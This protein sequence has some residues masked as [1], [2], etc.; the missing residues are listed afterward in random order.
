MR[1]LREFIAAGVRNPVL[2]NLI[3]VCALA[4][5]YF[6][7]R[8]MVQEAYPEFSVDHVEIVI[9]WPGAA[10]VDVERAITIPVEEAVEGIGGVRQ[11]SSHSSDDF[12]S[13]WLTLNTRGVDVDEVIKEVRNE[14]DQISHRLPPDAEK[15]IIRELIVR[16]EVI[17]I[18]IS[19]DVSERALKR[20]AK[21][22]KTDLLAMPEVSQVAISG[23]RDDEIIVELSEESLQA[24]NLTFDQ[25]MAAIARSSLELS[26]GT[27]RTSEEE[28]SLRIAGR[29]LRASEYEKLVVIERPNAVVHLSDI[30]EIREGFE[31]QTIRGRFNGKPALSVIVYK[32]PQE[33]TT[34]I[35]RAVRT[36]VESQQGFLPQRVTMS[37]WADSS[38]HVEDRVQ[39]L[40][41]N[42]LLG[43]ILVFAALT[44]FLEM[45]TAFW[46]A[47]GIPV[48]FGGALIVMAFSGETL[49]MI[50]MFALIMVSGII[51]DDAI[52]IAE[53]IHNRRRA[54][55]APQLASINGAN[56]V[57]VPVLGSS[58]TTIMTFIPLLFI[59]GAMGNVIRVLPVVVIGAILASA[60]EAFG[61]LPAHLAG[62]KVNESNSYKRRVN[63]LRKR[64]EKAIDH[65]VEYW[66]RPVYRLSL[67]YR[68]VTI[69]GALGMLAFVVGLV[70][71]DR[72]S[73][74]FYPKETGAILRARVRYPEG[75]PASLSED[76]A[77]RM[78]LAALA[79]N[80]DPELA[81]EV[82]GPLVKN[83]YAV[84]GEFAD[85]WPERG[86]NLCE[87][88]IELMPA[89]KRG[90]DEQ[91]IIEKWREKIG[92]VHDAIAY[93][94]ER[95]EIG[96]VKAPI[97]VRFMGSNLEDLNDARARL[98][99]KLSTYAGVT[100]VYSDLLPGKRELRVKLKP[101]ARTL[102][103]TLED[104]ARQLRQ[105]FY[106][107]E[108]VRL[109]RGREEVIVRV[110]YREEERRSITELNQKHFKLPTGQ[111]IPFEEAVEVAW[112]QGFAMIG[113]QDGKRRVRVFADV[114]ERVANATRVFEELE[115][116]YLPTLVN[117]YNDMYWAFGGHRDE[118]DMS[119]SSLWTGF[120]M[121]MLAVYA[122]LAGMLRSYIKPVIILIAVPFGIIGAVFG[123]AIMGFDVT[124]MSLFGVVA[125]SGV[126]VNDSLVLLD[127]V[128]TSIR[129]GKS[130][131]EAVAG[132][133]ERRFRAVVLTSITTVAGLAPLML[134]RSTQAAPLVPMAISLVFGIVFATV[135]TLF[136]VPSLYLLVND[137]RRFAHWLL[138]GGSYPL[139]EDVEEYTQEMLT[140]HSP[141]A[142][143]ATSS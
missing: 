133:G 63:A 90:F 11:V 28:V 53:N 56:G 122:V 109:R 13:V 102:G 6:A 143:S 103:L 10:T 23:V 30:A 69:A 52:V 95:E 16:G 8:D 58:L 71:G 81:S 107:G 29:R 45:R 92:K 14:V 138:R 18:A 1:F 78:E 97:E 5:G 105:G 104:V 46:V 128:N 120:Q 119:L 41:S 91:V 12:S 89:E 124:L 39:M 32:T 82:E 96:P 125:L 135:L 94:I 48:A 36:Y 42:G 87:V 66:Y 126:V 22:T 17:S 44:L 76:T 98:S 54:G 74:I 141:S 77:Q 134:E 50:S 79:L 88:R 26:A 33:D 127:Q 47:I 67:R 9:A 65:V 131:A 25:V 3:M 49:N 108:A 142:Q 57:A 86:S 113:H 137:M 100:D 139:P 114:D 38:R 4:G 101:S 73:F 60:V 112:D 72:V 40:V 117:D 51:V 130:V 85:F 7:A 132:A 110:R 62:H 123:H 34:S 43:I 75:T 118:M 19:G 68:L 37:F 61:I 115:S 20:V 129:E 80:D 70:L 24:Y 136:I 84:V 31:E 93:F 121:A 55:D 106:G 116:E 64:L 27:I 15:P 140:E 83:T 21:K 99:E 111:R 35:A 59:L 2:A